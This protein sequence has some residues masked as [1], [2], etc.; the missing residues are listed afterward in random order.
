MLYNAL[1]RKLLRVM[2]RMSAI[3]PESAIAPDSACASASALTR[4]RTRTYQRTTDRDRTYTLLPPILRGH[5]SGCWTLSFMVRSR[6]AETLSPMRDF[7]AFID[8]VARVHVKCAAEGCPLVRTAAQLIIPVRTIE[9]SLH[10]RAL[11]LHI[12]RHKAQRALRTCGVEVAAC[13]DDGG[14][15]ST[16]NVGRSAAWAKVSES[17][18]RAASKNTML[19]SKAAQKIRHESCTAHPIRW[20]LTATASRCCCTQDRQSKER[21]PP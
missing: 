7:D 16:K 19:L 4:R 8:A 3:A 21:P 20:R 9:A 6:S 14:R 11:H 18:L 10:R 17:C 13:A 5:H 1:A 15:L 12:I 2:V